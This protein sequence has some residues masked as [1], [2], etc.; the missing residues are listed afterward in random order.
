MKSIPVWLPFGFSAALSAIVLVAYIASGLSDAW[1]TP[2]LC[3]LP[4][5]FW[6]VA[7][8]HRQTREYIKALEGRIQQL[9]ASKAA[10]S[11]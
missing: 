9:E 10:A 3:F 6:F 2:F 5:T 11:P 8:S 7:A 4:M 1:I